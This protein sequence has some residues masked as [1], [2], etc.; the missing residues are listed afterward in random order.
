MT[1]AEIQLIH[2]QSLI[3]YWQTVI[4]SGYYKTKKI[5]KTID[6]VETALNDEELLKHSMDILHRH[7][8]TMTTL[9]NEMPEVK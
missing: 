6:G 4:L 5:Y 3:T 2:R 9:V 1:Y 7:I 8:D